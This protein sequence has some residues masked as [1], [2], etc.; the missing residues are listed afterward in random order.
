MRP[1]ST[2]YLSGSYRPKTETRVSCE[3]RRRSLGQLS[4]AARKRDYWR[5]LR[6][7]RKCGNSRPLHPD[8]PD[9]DSVARD[10][11]NR[12]T[13]AFLTSNRTEYV[14]DKSE[15]GSSTFALLFGVLKKPRPF[16]LESLT[17]TEP[18]RNI[19]RLPRCGVQ[20]N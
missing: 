14:V 15:K 11:R 2:R 3:R 17:P 12:R 16:H 18:L 8:W 9:G 4:S 13:R 7:K 19:L 20:F 5:L 1:S 10:S 6:H